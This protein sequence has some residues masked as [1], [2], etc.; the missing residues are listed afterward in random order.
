MQYGSSVGKT[1]R[2]VGEKFCRRKL[3]LLGV[4]HI[5]RSTRKKVLVSYK[6]FDI[7]KVKNLMVPV[8]FVTI[9]NFS[10]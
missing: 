3:Q 6:V 1:V 2:T 10:L 5:D 9:M 4:T 7:C 8:F